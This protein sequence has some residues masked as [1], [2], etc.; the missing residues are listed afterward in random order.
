MFTVGLRISRL[1]RGFRDKYSGVAIE[2]QEILVHLYMIAYLD[3]PFGFHWKSSFSKAMIN[4]RMVVKEILLSFLIW[5][6]QVSGLPVPEHHQ[7]PEISYTDYKI[8]P[9]ALKWVGMTSRIDGNIVIVRDIT[10][11]RGDNWYHNEEFACVL[12]H[13]LTHHLQWANKVDMTEPLP[14]RIQALCLDG[15]NM[16]HAAKWAWDRVEYCAKNE[17]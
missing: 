17:C 16:P 7:L 11:V 15:Y 4:I 14:Y 1:F 9:N 2:T 12:A 3:P 13:E 6:S 8:G 5:V 10:M